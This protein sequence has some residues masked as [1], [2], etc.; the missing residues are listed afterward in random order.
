MSGV[1]GGSASSS[2]SGSKASK[3][4]RRNP[5]ADGALS[6]LTEPLD[7]TQVME[8]DKS[9][10]QASG[11][12]TGRRKGLIEEAEMRAEHQAAARLTMLNLARELD[13][14]SR[15]RRKAEMELIEERR[16][17]DILA[18]E[19]DAM[20]QKFR[21][22]EQKMEDAKVAHYSDK[23]RWGTREGKFASMALLWSREA[24]P[25]VQVGEGMAALAEEDEEL[26]HTVE[27]DTI[28][29]RPKYKR[30]PVRHLA[31]GHLDRS[32]GDGLTLLW[33]LK[34]WHE[35]VAEEKKRRLRDAETE[36][37]IAALKAEMERMKENYEKLLAEE[38]A[39]VRQLSNRIAGLLDEINKLQA[40]C[41][42]LER[43]KA[44]LLRKLNPNGEGGGGYE[45]LYR[46]YQELLAKYS[47]KEAENERQAQA[48]RDL[49]AQL[50]KER[51]ESKAEI[52]KLKA[53]IRE[54]GAELQR[55]II[56]AKHLREAALRAKRDAAS[57]LS[58]EKF[59]QLIAELEEMRDRLNWLGAEH[60]R[61]R[62]QNRILGLKLDQNKRRLELERQ[63]LPLLHKVK[64]P[65][66][67]KNPLFQK[68]MAAL[69]AA[70]MVPDEM[71]PNAAASPE[72]LRMAH[73]QSAGAID[74]MAGAGGGATRAPKHAGGH[75]LQGTY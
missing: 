32:K 7:M 41:D 75:R 59:A 5:G 72:R 18:A 36:A 16:K 4:S 30:A 9:G 22:A 53:E 67:P 39:K 25:V 44:D 26:S 20:E 29:E 19:R 12:S 23:L 66:G 6:F 57:S 63:F 49:E 37:R 46:K 50:D 8:V 35:Q 52:T 27:L 40:R 70:T 10:G 51:E 43:D 55:Q 11:A 1:D 13:Q 73:S 33:I 71:A 68:N 3:G 42:Q 34:G 56:F 69:A 14:A 64:G 54:L 61:G 60:Q 62:E 21:E 48:I 45:E 28:E 74:A 2:R 38:R 24:K 65:V 58:P 47:E 15:L 17:N 31:G